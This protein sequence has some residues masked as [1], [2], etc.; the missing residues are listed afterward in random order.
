M[1]RT[2]I[3]PG[4]LLADELEEIGI[5]SH[6]LAISIGIPPHRLRDILKGIKPIS[7]DT[8][9]RLGKYFGISDGFWLNLQKIYELDLA[10][11]TISDQLDKIPQRVL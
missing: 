7:A 9:L 11:Q 5:S 2:P 3:H 6:E 1:A 8:S 4:I 10:R